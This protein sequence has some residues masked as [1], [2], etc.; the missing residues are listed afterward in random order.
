MINRVAFLGHK[1]GYWNFGSNPGTEQ[2]SKD[3]TGYSQIYSVVVTFY[4][5]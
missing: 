1:F 5:W 4:R 3:Y 2:K